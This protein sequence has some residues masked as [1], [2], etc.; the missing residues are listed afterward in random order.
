MAKFL[1][2]LG[3]YPKDARELA[4]RHTIEGVKRLLAEVEG[5]GG[6]KNTKAYLRTVLADR[7]PTRRAAGSERERRPGLRL[8]KGGSGRQGF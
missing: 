4:R 6:V 1:R 8:V 7:A 3:I 2:E 5:R